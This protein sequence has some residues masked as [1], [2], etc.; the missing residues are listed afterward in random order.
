L[1]AALKNAFLNEVN[2]L[3]AVLIERDPPPCRAGIQF[4]D[5][6]FPMAPGIDFAG[7]V[8]PAPPH[9]PAVRGQCPADTARRGHEN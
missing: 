4:L 9:C 2:M 5:V 8:D 7:A 6:Q 3:N 1:Q